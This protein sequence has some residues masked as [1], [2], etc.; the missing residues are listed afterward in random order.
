M[1]YYSENT[2]IEKKNVFAAM[3]WLVL[4]CLSI[5]MKWAFCHKLAI[6]VGITSTWYQLL[7]LV[8]MQ[9]LR[10]HEYNSM[11]QMC[12]K[13]ADECRV[14]TG[15]YLWHIIMNAVKPLAAWLQQQMCVHHTMFSPRNK[16]FHF[17][18][19]GHRLSFPCFVGIYVKLLVYIQ[20][21]LCH[22]IKKLHPVNII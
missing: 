18:Q 3:I 21:M 19:W 12:Q 14:D 9:N 2:A 6:D 13:V 8:T 16:R 22:P 17:W 5:Y 1:L 11:E 4:E 20:C 15:T 10:C 7:W